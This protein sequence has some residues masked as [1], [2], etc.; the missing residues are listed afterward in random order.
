[1]DSQNQAIVSTSYQAGDSVFQQPST[2]IEKSLE[3]SIEDIQEA[4]DFIQTHP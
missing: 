1:M 2:I 4:I 3:H